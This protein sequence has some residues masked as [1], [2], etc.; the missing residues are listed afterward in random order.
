[1]GLTRYT[2]CFAL[3]L[4]V[5]CGQA[6][7]RHLVGKAKSYS[8]TGSS[9][10][11]TDG[12]SSNG[13]TPVSTPSKG[14]D[15]TQPTGTTPAPTPV[16]AVPTLKHAEDLELINSWKVGSYEGNDLFKLTLTAALPFQ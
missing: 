14:T 12:T 11:E 15:K 7:D 16:V 5:G 1:M 6:E 3:I 2:L 10:S 8:Q 9:D 13:S 4:T